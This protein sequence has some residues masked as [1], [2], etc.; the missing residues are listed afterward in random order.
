MRGFLKEFKEFIATGN[1]VELAVAVILGAAVGAVIKAFTDGIIMQIVAAIFGK[2]NFD[3]VTITLRENVGADPAN[4]GEQL[5]AVLEALVENELSVADIV[6]KGYPLDLVTRVQNM[7]YSAEYKR[8][9]ASPG[10]KVTRR[11]F[12]RDRRY[13]I[14]NRFRDR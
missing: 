8:R 2:P 6:A 10:V 11:N 14:T 12:G 5:D 9:Q 1:M 7:L 4:P 3:D 13:P